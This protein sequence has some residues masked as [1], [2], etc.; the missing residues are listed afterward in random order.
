MRTTQT[1]PAAH[2]GLEND[3]PDQPLQL[4]SFRLAGRLFGVDI[5][6]VKEINNDIRITPVFQAPPAV[7]GYMNIRGRIHLVVDLRTV[8]EFPAKAV[9]KDS[10]VIIFKPS[11]DEAFGALVD[12][13][14]DVVTV[15]RNRIEERRDTKKDTADKGSERRVADRALTE[16]VCKLD[17]DLLVILNAAEILKV[18]E[19]KGAAR[20]TAGSEA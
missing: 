14:A 9:D 18:I 3:S 8:F 7:A 6:K 2:P 5:L 12:K 4:C 10:K 20:T 1:T 11:V 13:V 16:G 15:S 17:Q 19:R